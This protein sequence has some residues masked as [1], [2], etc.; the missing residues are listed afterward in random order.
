LLQGLYGRQSDF[1]VM[2]S[3]HNN[4]HS[5]PGQGTRTRIAAVNSQRQADAVHRVTK[6]VSEEEISCYGRGF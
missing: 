4:L 5:K 3:K 1:R 2:A 6:T